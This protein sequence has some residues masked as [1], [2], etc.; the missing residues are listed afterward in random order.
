ML[1]IQTCLTGTVFSYSRMLCTQCLSFFMIL[2][3]DKP[4]SDSSKTSSLFHCAALGLV[5]AKR[6]KR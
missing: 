5:H 3:D 4:V 6:I 2:Q 1:D